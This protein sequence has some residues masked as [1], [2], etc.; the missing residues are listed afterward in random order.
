M[1]LY[2]FLIMTENYQTYIEHIYAE[3]EKQARNK[4]DML[5]KYNVF[6]MSIYEV[7]Q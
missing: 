7:T 5:D 1:K 3:N 4:F 6:K 2:K